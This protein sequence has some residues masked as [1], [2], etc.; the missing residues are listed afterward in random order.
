GVRIGYAPTLA[1]ALD[2]V[3]GGGVGSA[4]TAPGGESTPPAPADGAQGTPQDGQAAA[5]APAPAPNPAPAPAPADRTAAVAELDAALA[6]LSAAQSTGDFAA[7][8]RAL[9]RV[10]AAVEAYQSTGG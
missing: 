2:Q 10:Q 6:E 8:G 1:A 4:A 7:Y 3:F 5:P 9:E